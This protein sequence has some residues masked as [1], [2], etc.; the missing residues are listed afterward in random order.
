MNYKRPT[1]AIK[2]FTLIEVLL[3]VSVFA[4]VLGAINSVFFSALRLR[5][6]SV[7]AFESALPLQQ[8]VSFIQKDLEG[9]MIPGGRLAGTFTTSVQSL[10]NNVA[11]IGERV[12]PDIYTSS[13]NVS[14]LARWADVQKVAYFLALPTN[15]LGAEGG[16]DLVRLVTRNLLPANVEEQELQHL[17]SGVESMRF[18]YY[19]G[20]A[21]ADT[22]TSSNFPVGIKVQITLSDDYVG[23]TRIPAPVELVVPVLVKS[24]TSSTGQA[25]GG[26]P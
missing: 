2:A 21:W 1:N 4:I 3:A 23:T 5:N 22:S 9:I 11:F 14:E 6:K 17:M 18:Q 24:P 26:T 25:D 7:E 13:G 19:D 8:A 20:L 15:T 10:S 16:K 12:S